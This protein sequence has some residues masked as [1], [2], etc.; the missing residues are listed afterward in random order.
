MRNL[1]WLGLLTLAMAAN[2]ANAQIV[3]TEPGNY[4]TPISTSPEITI[5]EFMIDD[6]TTKNKEFSAPEPSPI[7]KETKLE[8]DSLFVDNACKDC[9]QNCWHDMHI[10]KWTSARPDGHAPAGVMGDH[11]HHAGEFMVGY[12]FMHMQMAGNRIGTT[13]LTP[14][15]VLNRG[16]VATPTDMIMQMHMLNFMYAPTDN[17]T[18]M[19]M[20]PIHERWMDHITRTGARFRT[21]SSGIGDLQVFGLWK[22]YDNHRQRVHLNLGM[23]FPTGQLNHRDAI[24]GNPDAILPYP[25]QLG[26]G[27]FDLLPGLTYLGQTDC[28]SWGVQTLGT[29]RLGENY[30]DYRR[31][32]D[33]T[34][35]GWVARKWTSWMS[36]SFRLQGSVWG[37]FAGADPNLNPNIISTT[38]PDLRGGDRIDAF[39]GMNLYVPKGCLKNFRVEIEAGTPIYQNLD[40]PQL[41]NDWNLTAVVQYSW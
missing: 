32:H 17:L 9:C 12:A 11:T 22:I 25:M 39:I 23:A 5:P 27:T 19:L 34:A 36:T 20:V 30:R 24:P 14:E 13:R 6:E 41:E 26:S 7:D 38:D 1:C 40:G 21:R 33:W 8:T 29:I 18:L 3:T 28:W 4:E 15:Q 10:M 37:D 2:A 16:Y 31:N 35:T